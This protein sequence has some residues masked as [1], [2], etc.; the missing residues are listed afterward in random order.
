MMNEI[1]PEDDQKLMYIYEWV[2]SLPLS[3][4]KKNIARDFSDGVL[5]AE[6]IKRY[7][8][9]YVELHNYPSSHSTKHKKQNWDTL[10]RKVLKRIGLSLSGKE[11]ESIINCEPFAIESIL[12]KFYNK[13]NSKGERIE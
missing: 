1:S 11:I 4:P 9:Q 7:Y 5:F 6:A 10:N 3:R 8:P 13:I 2:D 12:S